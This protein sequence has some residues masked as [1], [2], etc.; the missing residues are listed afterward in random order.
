MR[1]HAG[2]TPKKPMTITEMARLGGIARA[3]KL[4]K[5]ERVKIATKAVRA[6][7]RKRKGK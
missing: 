1:Y 6:R 2:M 3:Q 4:T 7:E 5:A